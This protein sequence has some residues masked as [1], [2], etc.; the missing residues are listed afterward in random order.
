MATRGELLYEGKAKKVYRTDDPDRY[1]VE[2]KDEATAF[3]GAKKG[4]ILNKGVL[5][6]RISAVFFRLLEENGV[7]THFVALVSD[8]EMLVK[9]LEIIMVEVVVRN[10]AAGSLAARLGL[11]EGAVLPCTVLEHYYKSDE[12]SD[13]MINGYH[14][15]ALGLATPAQMNKI[16]ALAL[17]TNEILREYLRDKDIELVDFN[18]NMLGDG[19]ARKSRTRRSRRKGGAAAAAPPRGRGP[20]SEGCP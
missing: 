7:P 9:N 10:I 18:E 2:F 17:K 20:G 6:N 14:I 16:N 1:L 5:N 15:Q 4:T 13:P 12:L 8:R 11:P 19:G 3:N